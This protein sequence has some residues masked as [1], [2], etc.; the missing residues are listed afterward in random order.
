M[1][2]SNFQVV[3]TPAQFLA[4]YKSEWFQFPSI[5]TTG[6]HVNRK[7]EQFNLLNTT[8]IH[9]RFLLCKSQILFVTSLC[10]K[11]ATVAKCQRS[12]D[13][14]LCFYFFLVFFSFSFYCVPCVRFHNKYKHNSNHI[15][16][17]SEHFVL[18][19]STQLGKDVLQQFNTSNKAFWT[20]LQTTV[21]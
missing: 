6:K 12:Y 21:I 5:Q 10:N 15:A 20:L 9:C 18:R 16:Y 8:R 19:K 7:D 4:L 1:I 2:K 3:W 17:Q 11:T 14:F 13:I